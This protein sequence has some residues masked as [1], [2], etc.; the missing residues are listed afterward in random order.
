MHRRD[1]RRRRRRRG[2]MAPRSTSHSRTRCR[3]P[4]RWRAIG[5]DSARTDASAE[6]AWAGAARARGRRPAARS[7]SSNAAGHQPSRP[8]PRGG[9]LQESCRPG[10]PQAVHGVLARV[11]LRRAARQSDAARCEEVAD[12][13]VARLA[14]DVGA[15]VRDDIERHERRAGTLGLRRE[16]VVEELLP[17]PSRPRD[18]AVEIEQESVESR[19]IDRDG[20]AS[21]HGLRP[22]RRRPIEGDAVRAGQIGGRVIH[23]LKEVEHSFIR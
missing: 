13:G 1:E 21:S 18:H 2:P 7:P 6:A 9:C 10:C 4:A 19:K 16:I 11:V 12:P 22:L 5:H 15:V 8:S 17:G 3:L 14:V 23:A 20:I